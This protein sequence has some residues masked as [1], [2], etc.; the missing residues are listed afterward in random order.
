MAKRKSSNSSDVDFAKEYDYV[1]N[2]LKRFAV[3][4]VG[5]F[6]LLIILALALQ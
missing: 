6:A 2:D 5:M 3:T 1:L 4:A